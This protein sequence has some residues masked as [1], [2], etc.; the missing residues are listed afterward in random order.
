MTR[1]CDSREGFRI[2][3]MVLITLGVL[4]GASVCKGEESANRRDRE[5]IW[6]PYDGTVH[7]EKVQ[8][9]IGNHRFEVP[10]HYLFDVVRQGR[11]MR[12]A[13]QWPSKRSIS[14]ETE[15]RKKVGEPPPQGLK[16]L[17]LLFFFAEGEKDL[18]SATV[19]GDFIS[20]QSSAERD[21]KLGL[22]I[23]RV[24]T[25]DYFWA[26]DERVRTPLGHRY[27]FE[28]DK[29]ASGRGGRCST[30]FLLK[31]GPRVTM[32]FNK[33]HIRDWKSIYQQMLEFI[34]SLRGKQP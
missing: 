11:H 8:I 14:E 23:H 29:V 20:R 10:A 16:D 28:C 4:S 15:Y 7:R 6:P 5:M 31:S 1:T 9:W 25:T 2:A 18:E 12:I 17:I 19:Y 21:E 22:Y 33:R 3:G 26:M 32:Y 30:S 24:K 27:L 13:V 34:E